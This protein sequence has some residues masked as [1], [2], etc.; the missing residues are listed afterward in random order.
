[1]RAKATLAL[2]KKETFSDGSIVQIVVWD[3][4]VPLMGSRHRYKYSLYFGKN[5]VCLVRYDNERGKGDHRH[6]NGK[7]EEYSFVSISSLL[8]DFWNDVERMGG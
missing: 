7:E 5:G 1:M 6:I 3:L 8:A 2:D 4:P